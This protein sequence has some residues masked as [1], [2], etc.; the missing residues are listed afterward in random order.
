MVMSRRAAILLTTL[1][2]AAC[3]SGHGQM[4]GD[5]ES[6]Q[7]YAAIA[8]D[9]VLHLAGNEP[10]WGGEVGG[11]TLTYLTPEHPDGVRVAATRFAGRN[12]ISFSGTLDG[13]DFML[14]VTPD[15]CSDGMSD[16]AYPFA[17][18]LEIGE[19]TRNGCAWSDR[20]PYTGAA[21]P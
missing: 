4:P 9:E 11:G 8:Q 12:G 2:L 13:A 3:H 19:D 15:A 20:H 14:A 16:R 10:F 18:T 6:R 21:Q 7:P 5:G 1:A 17:A